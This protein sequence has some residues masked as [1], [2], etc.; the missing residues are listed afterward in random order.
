VVA[1]QVAVL[2]F[3]ANYLADGDFAL[4]HDGSLERE[5]SGTGAVRQLSSADF[6][7]LNYK[8]TNT[9][10]TLLS[11]VVAILKDVSFPLKVQ[12]DF[13]EKTPI[14][15]DD[16]HQ[17]LTA[18]EALRENSHI[19]MVIGCLADWNLRTFRRLDP[20]LKLGLDFA[21][22]LDAPVDGMLRLPIR[23]GAYGYLDD[24]PLALRRLQSLESYLRDRIESLLALVPDIYEVY[25]RKD[26]VSQA[27]ND[28]FNPIAFIHDH[29]EAGFV[30]VWTIDY[31]SEAANSVMVQALEAG[32]DQITTNTA[33]QWAEHFA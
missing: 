22:H 33:L 2:E 10:G 13:K 19:T 26:F 25:L 15:N 24:H 23:L 9:P 5:T 6:K 4:I 14:T 8:D 1:G 18:T 27:L 16:A 32:A 3:D 7:K 21:F 17:L 31:G 20:E 29:V 12:L 28:G 30:D 11:E